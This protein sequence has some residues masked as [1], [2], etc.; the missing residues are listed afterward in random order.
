MRFLLLAVCVVLSANAAG[1]DWNESHFAHKKFNE[2]LIAARAELD[3]AKR[4]A[5]YVDMQGIVNM[6]GGTVVPLFANY[7]FAMSNKVQH[8]P[9]MAGNWD[10]DG[11][12]SLE[13]WWFG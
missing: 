6:E 11:D 9:K 7:V 8:G 4:R 13:R 12:K 5:M 3:E 10:M 2:L 1:A